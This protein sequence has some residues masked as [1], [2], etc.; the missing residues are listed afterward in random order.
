MPGSTP[1]IGGHPDEGYRSLVNIIRNKCADFLAY[2]L[3]LFVNSL[4]IF[5]NPEYIKNAKPKHTMAETKR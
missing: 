4:L 5:L 2:L 1:P 3:F